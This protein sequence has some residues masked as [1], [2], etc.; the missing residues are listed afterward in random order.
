M[1]PFSE[2]SLRS[3]HFV[4]PE[5]FFIRKKLCNFFGSLKMGFLSYGKE[6]VRLLL[7]KNDTS[8]KTRKSQEQK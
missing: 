6:I 3:L 8:D 4:E 5:A 7:S 1:P 2:L